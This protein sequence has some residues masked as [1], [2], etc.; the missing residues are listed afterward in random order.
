MTSKD[1]EEIRQ[2]V[3]YGMSDN[4]ASLVQFGKYVAM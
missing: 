2:V 3:L 4:M 1:F